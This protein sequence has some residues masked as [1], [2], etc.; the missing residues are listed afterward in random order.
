MNENVLFRSNVS[1][2]MRSEWERLISF[3][4]FPQSERLNCLRLAQNGFY[5]CGPGNRVACYSCGI[6]NTDWPENESIA[7]IHRRLSP[8]CK[9]V[10][11]VENNTSREEVANAVCFVGEGSKV[12]ERVKIREREE[13]DSLPLPNLGP[14]DESV[15]GMSVTERETEQFL[16]LHPI[17]KEKAER[18]NTFRTWKF[19]NIVQPEMLADAGFFYTGNSVLTS[20]PPADVV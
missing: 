4:A 6:F 18:L 14:I 11:G 1:K 17:H 12:H 9:F 13:A 5:V 19:G 7:Q 8:L 20:N 2:N 3:K 16:V 10:R 15:A